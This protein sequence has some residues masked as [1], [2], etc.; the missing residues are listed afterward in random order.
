[1]NL[2][3]NEIR[4]LEGSQA[5]GF[6]ELCAQLARVEAPE[7]ANFVRKGSPDSGVEC[8]CM[9]PDGSEWGWQAKFFT[10]ALETSQWRQLDDSVKSA[11]DGHPGLVHYFVCVPRNRSDGKI[12]GRKSELDRWNEHVSKWTDLAQQRGMDVEFEWWGSSELIERISRPEHIGRRYYWFETREFDQAW[13]EQRL[14]KSI[15]AAGPRYTPE[16][17]VELPIALQ[18]QSF[19]RS[20]GALQ[21][22]KSEA[23][24]IRRALRDAHYGYRK[25]E[26][27]ELPIEID[28]LLELGQTVLDAIHVLSDSPDNKLP[29]GTVLECIEATQ[30]AATQVLDAIRDIESQQGEGDAVKRDRYSP[31]SPLEQLMRHVLSLSWVLRNSNDSLSHADQLF[32]SDLLIVDGA[33]GTGKTHLLCDFAKQRIAKGAPTILLMGQ[34]FLSLDSSWP[35]ALNQLDLSTVS[36]EKFVGALEVAAQVATERALII[37]DAINEGRGVEIWPTELGPFLAELRQSRWIDVILSVRSSYKDTVI[38]DAVR[39]RAIT[40]SHNGF[41]GVEYDALQRFCSHY[42][43]EFPSIPTPHTEFRNPLFLKTICRALQE[44]GETTI[45]KGLQGISTVFAT[46]L[47]AINSRLAGPTELNFDPMRNLVIEAVRAV[48]KELAT[49]NVRRL[50]RAEALTIVDQLLPGRE[51]S[52]SLYAA[53]IAEEILTEDVDWMSGNTDDVVTIISY[54][55]LA[56]HIVAEYY[57]STHVDPESPGEAFSES[58]AL[59]F[60]QDETEYVPSGLLEALCVQIPEWT[61]QELIR[62]APEL[63]NHPSIGLAF[64]ESI[65]WRSIDAFTEETRGVLNELSKS[66]QVDGYEVLNSLILAST[67]PGHPFNAQ[68]L[69]DRLRQDA[70]P[71]RDAWWSIYLHNA[72]QEGTW[73]DKGPIDRLV[74]WASDRSAADSLDDEVVGLAATTLSW[75]LT[76]SNRFLR[77]KATKALVSLLTGRLDAARQLIEKF[78]DVDDPYVSERVYAAA[79]GV[80][81]R[82]RDSEGLAGLAT[83]VYESVFVSGS[84]PVHILLRDYARGVIER[85][86]HLG[87]KIDVDE[88]LIRPPYRSTWPHI[89]G[90]EETQTLTPNEDDGAFDGGSLVWSRNRIRN[91][92]R[93]ELLGD[94]GHYVIGDS[95]DQPWL[96][97]RLSAESWKSSAQRITALEDNLS[98]PERDAYDKFKLLEDRAPDLLEL[99]RIINSAADDSENDVQAEL[100]QKRQALEAAKRELFSNL[101][102]GHREELES[103]WATDSKQPPRFDAREIQRYVLWRVFDLGWTIE[104]FGEFDRFS[105]G[106]TGRHATK[107]ERMGKKYQWIAYHEI[108]AY[109]SDHFQFRETYAANED[110]QYY[111]GPWQLHIRDIDPSS[112]VR[113]TPG[114][115]SGGQHVPSWWAKERFDE[116]GLDLDYRDWVANADAIPVTKHLIQIDHPEDASLWLSLNGL[117]IWKEPIPADSDPY[118]S[119][120]RELWLKWTSHLVR[121]EK[122]S[123][124]LESAMKEYFEPGFRL[125]PPSFVLQDMYL[126]EYGWSV[127]YRHFAEMSDKETDGVD[128]RGSDGDIQLLPT[129]TEFQAESGGFDASVETGFHI[130]LSNSGMLAKLGLQWTGDAGAYHDDSGRLVAFDPTAYEEGPSSI[131]IR[132]DLLRRYL[133]QE[134]LAICWIISGEKWTIG[135]HAGPTDRTRLIIRG[136]YQLT[137]DGL[138]GQVQ[139]R[140]DPAPEDDLRK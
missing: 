79:Y 32:N 110:G 101:S 13:F 115:T 14:D 54:D 69:N 43:L 97:L 11:L 4:A 108:L 52:R 126:G 68:F 61:G 132:E 84:P 19:T 49:R 37:V 47:R 102:K 88:T 87:A 113:S 2:R 26:E 5:S 10:A 140:V 93:G 17:H 31:P 99:I 38:P 90:E 124:V 36:T 120:Q 80:A 100:E 71:D 41:E 117:C 133:D 106:S 104:R 24:P 103:I 25:I 23:I 78:A 34:R 98:E 66:G 50:P 8:Y 77:D 129:T 62:L 112:P 70:M 116:W 123:V 92:V 135:G 76:T 48:A 111:Q 21:R 107:P 9:L 114:G 109:L 67:V 28:E 63:E 45:P 18:L 15:V 55:R 83:S 7:D 44:R 16:L 20:E 95:S 138:K 6:E 82:S 81:M 29:I 139:F 59:G 75:T 1:M 121:P 56:D 118:E 51:F 72:W 134:E 86:L 127:A 53:L 137:D 122:V 125:E 74:D 35:Q 60:L 105:I 65:I 42:E 22:I 128:I 85:A 27:A 46:Y 94:F 131:L 57:L 3:W 58:G 12:K 136:A 91:S 30:A 96:A 130:G 73:G 64:L 89:P 33:A 40:L 119:E 39:K